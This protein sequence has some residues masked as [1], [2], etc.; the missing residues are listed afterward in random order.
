[1]KQISLSE[2]PF[3]HLTDRCVRRSFLC[4]VVDGVN[5][6]HRR[7]WIV[8]RFKLLT[9]TFA[10][11]SASYAIM[12]NH[13]HILARVDVA[14]AAAWLL[15]K[16]LLSNKSGQEIRNSGKWPSIIFKKFLTDR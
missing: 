5:F 7:D 14:K 2:P 15:Q 4:G 11:D 13:Y 6:E 1:M 16:Y 10:I 8:E 9:N 3:Y 12:M